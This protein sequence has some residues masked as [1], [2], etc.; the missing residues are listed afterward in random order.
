MEKSLARFRKLKESFP[1]ELSYPMEF[2]QDES[3]CNTVIED[4]ESK[5]DG[6]KC[7]KKIASSTSALIPNTR[8]IYM[9]VWR[10][11]IALKTDCES[12]NFRFVVYIG[13]ASSTEASLLKRFKSEYEAVINKNPDIHW[14]ESNFCDRERR[15]SKVLNLWD[16]E[17]WYTT[18]DKCTAEEILNLEKRLINI[19]NPPGNKSFR[20]QI[21]ASIDKQR[22]APAFEPAF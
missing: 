18:M 5:S 16:L 7:I 3:F 11:S 19:F 14:D 4:L 20:Q 10:P 22:K 1:L 15:I 8:G 2:I 17:Y 9:F 13:S 12:C 6:W 21:R